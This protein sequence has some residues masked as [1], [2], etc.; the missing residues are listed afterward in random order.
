MKIRYWLCALIF[1]PVLLLAQ[2][3]NNNMNATTP[4]YRFVINDDGTATDSV[5]GL[6]WQRCPVGYRLEDSGNALTSDDV[7]ELQQTALLDWQ[8]ALQFAVDLNNNGGSAGFSDWRVPNIKE[9]ASIIEFRCYGPALNL[10]IFPD[11]DGEK[12]WSST[13]RMA[14]SPAIINFNFGTYSFSYIDIVDLEYTFN[15]RLVRGGG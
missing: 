8:A 5:T 13:P 9:L 11:V 14:N 15:V 4:D 1:S 10:A 12:F 3:C 7:C 2:E 6:L